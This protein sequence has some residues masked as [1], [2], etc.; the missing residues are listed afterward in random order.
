MSE[1]KTVPTDK[2]VQA[3]LD[4]VEDDQKRAD[5]WTLVQLM[6]DITGLP[7]QMWGG[8]IIG[9]GKI[10]YKYASG[11]EGDMMLIG[12]SPRKQNLALY[13]ISGSDEY[14]TLLTKLGKYKLGKGCL[15]LNRLKDVDM[16]TL[17]EMIQRAVE[18]TRKV[19][20][21]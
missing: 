8:A 12:F 7:P 5:S 13:A 3:F 9:F 19:N 4:S 2:S 11:R 6:Q 17:K 1:N 15:Y 14:E 18:H 16:G 10:H 21:S 20:P